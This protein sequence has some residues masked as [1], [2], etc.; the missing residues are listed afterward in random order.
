MSEPFDIDKALKALQYRQA[1][2]GKDRILILLIKQLNQAAPA[3]ELDSHLAWD[4]NANHK[5]VR[6][7]KRSK[8]QPVALNW[9]RLTTIMALLNFIS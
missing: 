7:E 9:P 8:H 2:T 4:A 5:K 3:D 1:L 6:P